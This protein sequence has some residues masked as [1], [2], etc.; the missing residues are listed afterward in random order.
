[1]NSELQEIKRLL[2]SQRTMMVGAFLFNVIVTNTS[3]L[4][5][6][7]FGKR[8]PYCGEKMRRLKHIQF[9]TCEDYKEYVIRPEVEEMKRRGEI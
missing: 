9:C 2:N 6:H 5:D 7:I 1:M 4:K 3:R 8:C